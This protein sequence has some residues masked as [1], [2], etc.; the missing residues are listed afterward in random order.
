MPDTEGPQPGGE[1][2]GSGEAPNIAAPGVSPRDGVRSAEILAP[3]GAVAKQIAAESPGHAYEARPQQGAMTRAVELALRDKSRLLVEAGTGVGKSFAYLV[4]A[5][6]RCIFNKEKVVVA[7]NTISLQEQLIQKDIPLLIRAI[8]RWIRENETSIGAKASELPAVVPVLVKGRGNYV[9]IRRLHLASQRQGSLFADAAP[10]RSLHVIE[11]WAS[12]TTDG[13]LATLPPLEVG[14]VW[15]HARSDSDNCMGR[16]CAHY[17]AC[18]FQRARREMEKAN[19]L[20]C[21]HAMYFADLALRSRHDDAAILPAYQH[22][23]L[24]EAHNVEDVACEHFG[25]SLTQAKVTRLLRTLYQPRRGKGYLTERGLALTDAE[26]AQRAMHLVHEAEFAARDFFDS[27]LDV[28][29]KDRTSS[30]RV[31]TRGIVPNILSPAMRAISLQL[32]T[33]RETT[34][35]EPDKFELNAY[36]KRAGDIADAAATLIDQTIPDAVY[37]IEV[38]SAGTGGRSGVHGARGARSALAFPRV[39]LACS[40]IEAGPILREHLFSRDIGVVLTSATLSTRAARAD[41][42][43]ERAET[44]FAYAMSQLGC[45]GALTMQLGSPFDYARQVVVHIDR[46]MPSPNQT[47]SG[48]SDYGKS[49]KHGKRSERPNSNSGPD[50]DTYRRYVPT[51]DSGE[52]HPDESEALGPYQR[53]IDALTSRIHEH[54][55]ATEG[56]AFVLFTSFADLY[57]CAD[58][59]ASRLERIDLPLLV[60]NRGGS[61]S[62]LLERFRENDRS[63]LFG[64]ASFWQGVDVRGHGLRNVIITRLPFEPPDRPVTQARLEKIEQRGGN[65]FMEESLP[66]AI[67][68]FKQGFGRLVRSKTDQGRVVVLDPRILQAR[69]GKRFLDALPSGLR[70]ETSE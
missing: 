55:R 51:D 5:M 30:G 40:P 24:D 20:V 42:P 36:A 19:L 60:Q 52:M 62:Q 32:K 34:A 6:L 38:T 61:R 35:S 23:I 11:D 22:V 58:A 25:V 3:D 13:T 67:I 28:W 69:Y 1:P 46:S 41:E 47:G 63:V 12:T 15:D 65:A 16:K 44:A 27:L 64:A 33:M 53:F 43:L 45:D 17:Q 29:E 57:E 2:R 56:G 21:N 49:S 7:T 37:W 66:R 39:T 4:P 8:D 48:R 68:R 54:V 50:P 31:R 9:S 26:A 70:I 59:I 18:F 14:E 10:L